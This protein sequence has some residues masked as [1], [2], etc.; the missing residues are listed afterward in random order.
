MFAVTGDGGCV[1]AAVAEAEAIETARLR[2]AAA[3]SSAA[4]KTSQRPTQGT[5]RSNA[6]TTSDASKTSSAAST[7]RA[8]SGGGVGGVSATGDAAAS[9]EAAR[10]TATP[11][12]RLSV[13]AKVKMSTILAWFW[14]LRDERQGGRL[15]ET[16]VDDIGLSLS[17]FVV[18]TPAFR[19]PVLRLPNLSSPQSER[20]PRRFV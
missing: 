17:C 7:D 12:D 1:L 5:T 19:A 9:T 2:A 14:V 18:L 8:S 3:A 4:A 20:Y 6:P 10:A 13:G 11:A 16:Q 15:D